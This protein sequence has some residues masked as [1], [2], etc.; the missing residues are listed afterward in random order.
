MTIPLFSPQ[1][2]FQEEQDKPLPVPGSPCCKYRSPPAASPQLLW[3]CDP[4]APAELGHR[5]LSG[6]T[7]GGLDGAWTELGGGRSLWHF[8]TLCNTPEFV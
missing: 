1:Y 8:L 7:P 2:E 6:Q 4:P 3:V 5:H